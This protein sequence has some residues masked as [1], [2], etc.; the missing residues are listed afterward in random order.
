M[1]PLRERA[2]QLDKAYLAL[3][4]EQAFALGRDTLLAP[5]ANVHRTVENGSTELEAT[6]R[7]Y[8]EGRLHLAWE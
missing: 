3:M 8:T 5:P 2:L 7:L 1:T 6:G 4:R